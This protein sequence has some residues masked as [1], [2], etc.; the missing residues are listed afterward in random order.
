M[1]TLFRCK[2]EFHLKCRFLGRGENRGNPEK[3]LLK[4]E[5]DIYNKVNIHK[6]GNLNID[7][8][9]QRMTTGS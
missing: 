4:Q 5:D 8:F 6:L 1:G 9:G 2:L 3:N 7:V